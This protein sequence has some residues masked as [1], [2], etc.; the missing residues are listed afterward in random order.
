MN[1]QAKTI[2]QDEAEQQPPVRVIDHK[3]DEAEKLSK[4]CQ[5]G[6]A[7]AAEKLLT[8]EKRRQDNNDVSLA[9]QYMKEEREAKEVIEDEEER[10]RIVTK[11]QEDLQK[12]RASLIATWRA[13]KKEEVLDGW[14]KTNS[15]FDQQK[16]MIQQK[17]NK[18][19]NDSMAR[20]HQLDP[21]FA[22]V[23]QH[24]NPNFYLNSD[25]LLGRR[26][27]SIVIGPKRAE[28]RWLELETGIRN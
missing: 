27:P 17:Q 26:L 1:A 18:L 8:A 12:Q 2:A 11:T 23:L 28:F 10:F 3:L 6:V 21:G 19:A 25:V 13:E 16:I 4:K 9:G 15:E 7:S 5:A 20:L 24:G 14:R 22:P